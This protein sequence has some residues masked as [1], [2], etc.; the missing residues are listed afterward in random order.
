MT[1]IGQ[2]NWQ[3]GDRGVFWANACDWSD[4]NIGSAQV[5]PENYGN[6]CLSKTGC[7]HFTWTYYKG[8]TCW[9]KGGNI[10]LSDATFTNDKSMLCGKTFGDQNIWQ[11][12]NGGVLW[13]HVCYCKTMT[14]DQ[15]KPPLKNVVIPA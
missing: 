2:I 7:T 6:T 13:A 1:P 12:G 8:G 10:Q 4:S 3:Q 5:A 14:L 11:S 9:L 15:Q